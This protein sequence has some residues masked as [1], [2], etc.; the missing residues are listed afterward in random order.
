MLLDVISDLLAVDARVSHRHAFGR[1]GRRGSYFGVQ[2]GLEQTVFSPI[3]SQCKPNADC[4]FDCVRGPAKGYVEALENRLKETER[5]LWRVLSTSNS[6]LDTLAEAFS[7]E[8]SRQIP[9][10]LAISTLET[11]EEKRSAIAYWEQFPLQGPD[12]VL[13]WKQDLDSTALV[14]IPDSHTF[15]DGAAYRP[16]RHTSIELT[17]IEGDFSSGLSQMQAEQAGEPTSLRNDTALQ[18]AAGPPRVKRRAAVLREES[19]TIDYAMQHVPPKPSK[20][21]HGTA[22]KFGLSQEFQDTFLW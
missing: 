3:A 18:P 19:A 22:T 11:T 13:A 9:R 8:L 21:N 1:E 17:S 2:A 10:S 14:A 16:S 5:V 6:T 20:P 12:E 15:G 4:N 7:T